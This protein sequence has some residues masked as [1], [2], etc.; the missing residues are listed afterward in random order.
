MIG[1]LPVISQKFN[2]ELVMNNKKIFILLAV[3]LT[4]VLSAC[5]SAQAAP[6]AQSDT[7][8]NPRTLAVSGSGQIYLTPDM[9]TISIGVQTEGKQAASVVRENTAQVKDVMAALKDFAI[10]DKDIRTTNFSISPQQNWGPNGE[11]LAVRYVVSNTVMVTVR[12]LEQ[13][14]ALLDAVVQAGSNQINGISFDVSDNTS[15]L[16]E[17]RLSAVKDARAQADQLA[18]AAGVT[19]GNVLSITTSTSG[20][21]S[22]YLRAANVESFAADVPISGGQVAVTVQVQMVYEIH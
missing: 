16:A 4:L 17:A 9:A 1:R 14:G 6:L 12:D 15:A 3:G 18:S 21:P 20:G 7:A 13:I 5:S 2:K 22:P 8:S 11:R 10:A 19:L